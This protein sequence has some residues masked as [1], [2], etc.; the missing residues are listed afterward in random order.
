MFLGPDVK[1]QPKVSIASPLV[2]PLK[3][4]IFGVQGRYVSKM[5]KIVVVEPGPHEWLKT[6]QIIVL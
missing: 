3:S 4:A 5:A 1:F 2:R 6:T